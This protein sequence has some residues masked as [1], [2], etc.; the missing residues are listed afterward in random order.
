MFLNK[1]FILF[2]LILIFF[3]CKSE[4]RD[5]V[6]KEKVENYYNAKVYKTSMEEKNGMSQEEV[7]NALVSKESDGKVKLEDLLSSLSD[8]EKDLI[9]KNQEEFVTR[10]KSAL[11]EDEDTDELKFVDKE[12]FI[13]KYEPDD[14]V[15]L[16]DF[17]VKVNRKGIRIRKI[18]VENLIKMYRDAK[19]DGVE[20][21]C[22]SAYRNYKYQ[23]SLFNNY[24]KQDGIQ[25]AKRYSAEPGHSEHQLGLAIDFG[26]ID[27]E[28]KNTDAGKWLAKNASNYGYEI[29]FPEGQENVTG[30]KFEPWHYRY[31]GKDAAYI[32]DNYFGGVSYKF[33]KFVYENRDSLKKIVSQT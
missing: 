11:K 16:D 13:D 8:T 9:L 15:Y 7:P 1:K 21:V 27:E 14:L 23:E 12:V 22:S 18:I 10:L 5:S 24:V 2:S 29:S 33:L 17:P 25:E 6:L 26:S 32:V 4:S 3:S 28:Y 20:V 30:Y 31:V 19:K